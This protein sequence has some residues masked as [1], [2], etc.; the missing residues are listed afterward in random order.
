VLDGK[1]FD[2]VL[3]LI[4]STILFYVAILI[5][6][7]IN[8]IFEKISQI[9]LEYFLLVFS[10]MTIQFIF[11]GIKYHRLLKKLN[12]PI[13]LRD[14]ILI[15]ISGLTLIATPGGIGTAIKSQ[16]LKKKYDQPFAK[17]LPIIFIERFTELLAILIILT[18]FLI[19]NQM[20]ESIIVV[21]V[22]YCFMITMYVLSSNTD[23][24]VFFKKLVSKFKKIEKL[25]ISFDNSRD[26]FSKLFE[27]KT[28]SESMIWSIFAK[29]SQFLAVY[30]IFLSLDIDINLILSG[31]IYYTSLVLGS[32][33][34]IPSGLIITESSMLG[35]LLNTGVDLSLASLSVILIRLITTWLGTIVGIFALKFLGIRNN[36]NFND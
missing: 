10:L 7:D 18:F 5:I 1:N 20:Y 36:K 35:L 27:F 24:F 14:S 26:S 32:L 29:I 15:F 13:S 25:I 34:F 4:I 16:I 19:W 8:L 31:Q 17:T 3:F 33:T 9:K 28:L 6:S 12:I 30:F 22:G 21:I 11:L 23:F 2:K